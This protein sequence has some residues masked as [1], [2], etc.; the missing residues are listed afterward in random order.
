MR[1][2][3]EMHKRPGEYEFPLVNRVVDSGGKVK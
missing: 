1:E 2:I 3:E